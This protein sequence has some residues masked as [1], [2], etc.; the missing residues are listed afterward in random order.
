MT[1][2]IGHLIR[3]GIKHMKLI[4]ILSKNMK[5]NII[6]T[7]II[8]S[9]P[10]MMLFL[11][12]VLEIYTGNNNEFNYNIETVLMPFL[13]AASVGYLIGIIF[14]SFL[15]NL[16]SKTLNYF[17]FVVSFLAYIQNLFFNKFIFI[18]DG[19][20]IDWNRIS[21]YSKIIDLM[22]ILVITLSIV[23]YVYFFKKKKLVNLFSVSK[24]V[25]LFILIIQFVSIILM[26]FTGITKHK[27][28]C[29][30]ILSGQEQYVYGNQNNIIVIV[31]DK[32]TNEEFDEL[33]L[34]HPE[35]TENLSDFT[36]YNN[37]DSTYAY[38]FPSLAH[39]LTG[40]D[41][42][43]TMSRAEWFDMVWNSDRCVDFYKS[44]HNEG[45]KCRLY[46]SEEA[47]IVLGNLDNLTD[48]YDNIVNSKPRIDYKMLVGLYTKMSIYKYS[49]Y[50][51]KPYFEISSSDAFKDIVVYD[52]QD[53]SVD[54]Y[55]YEVKKSL[56]ENGISVSESDNKMFT[57]MHISGLHERNNDTNGNYVEE[58]SVSLEE[59]KI[60]LAKIVNQYLDEIK[61]A[62]LYDN[63]TIIIMADHGKNPTAGI[64][65]QPIF[66]IK[67][68]N[69]KH[70]NMIINKSPI[71]YDDFQATILNCADIEYDKNEYGTSIFDWKETDSRERT[72]NLLEDGFMQYTYTGDRYDLMDMIKSKSG[73]H[74]KKSQDW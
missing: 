4:K 13:G 18:N 20:N 50:C 35:L 72:L 70:T 61:E 60:G 71:S 26:I 48:K 3:V 16:V 9:V 22:W 23:I 24:Y 63:S 32:F 49:P 39:I 6:H 68:Q 19:S 2:L 66:L 1:I 31:L 54:Y 29:H 65:P 12:G 40:Q 64:D 46:S 43:I 34:S 21:S 38:T 69:E 62:G 67:R 41:P 7:S 58:Y 10:V 52:N 8:I 25:S 42:D 74:T 47:Y 17:I 28:V 11:T 5:D 56:D 45:Y 30:R 33:L 37:A 73:V 57:F 55:N 36:Y 14:I 27:E 51:I 44:L 15:P 59:T 53:G